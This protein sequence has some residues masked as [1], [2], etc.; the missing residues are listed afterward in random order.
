MEKKKM[1]RKY[2]IFL[3]NGKSIVLTSI[4][5]KESNIKKTIGDLLK[6]NLICS[7]ETS[8]D[9]LVAKT[10]KII[11]IHVVDEEPFIKDDDDNE[12][13]KELNPDSEIELESENQIISKESELNLYTEEEFNEMSLNDFDINDEMNDEEINE[14][15]ETISNLE[16]SIHESLEKNEEN[17]EVE[18][19]IKKR[20]YTKKSK[21][22][23][24][25][26]VKNIKIEKTEVN[27]EPVFNIS[28]LINNTSDGDDM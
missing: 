20:R 21:E 1:K 17:L 14:M 12:Q 18:Q 22:T 27:G 10:N 5:K 28:E 3:E 2:N 25:K 24:P 23:K 13:Y 8:T 19:P 26:V 16:K 15:S 4:E 7:F 9:L 11:A 6:S